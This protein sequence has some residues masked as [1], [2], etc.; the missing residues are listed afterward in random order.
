MRFEII[1]IKRDRPPELFGGA[2]HIFGAFRPNISAAQQKCVESLCVSR[3]HHPRGVAYRHSHIERADDRAREVGLRCKN[4]AGRSLKGLGPQRR[5]VAGVNQHRA[6][7][8]I[9]AVAPHAAFDEVTGAKFFADSARIE[10]CTAELKAR[11]AADD[12]KPRH[13]GKVVN[14]L[15]CKPVRE[16]AMVALRR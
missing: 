1:G 12:D 4:V 9:V 8:Q 7:A 16:P 5:L 11:R 3:A 14:Q 6:D 10:I 2:Q 13:A 15:V